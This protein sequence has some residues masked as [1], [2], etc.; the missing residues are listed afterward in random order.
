MARIHKRWDGKNQW[1]FVSVVTDKRK[2]V[3][4][5]S[6]CCEMLKQSFREIRYYHE[7][8][9]ACLVILEDHWHAIISPRL[10]AVIETI[11]GAV[12]QNFMNRIWRHQQRKTIWQS[13]FLDRRLRNEK[14]FYFHVEYIRSNPVKHGYV[15]KLDEYKWCFIHNSPFGE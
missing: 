12:K 10:P 4:S 9:L 1:Y 15:D 5:N 14:D 2:P 3:F 6:D 7:Y 11:V 8:R 13:Q